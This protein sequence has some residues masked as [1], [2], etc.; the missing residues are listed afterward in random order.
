METI[1]KDGKYSVIKN[2]EHYEVHH[3]EEILMTPGGKVAHTL[4][5]PIAERLMKDWK[6]Q[7]YNS[8]T[9]SSSLLSYHF[10]M[11]ENFSKYDK[12]TLLMILNSLGW[13]NDVLLK[14]C[15]AADPHV[16]MEWMNLFGVRDERIAKIKAWMNNATPMQLTAMTCIYNEFMSY[17]IA[18]LMAV[19]VEHV[20][21]ENHKKAIK[22]IFNFY[23]HWDNMFTFDDFW[24][25]FDCFRL[26]YGE[27]FKE[28][29]KHLP[30]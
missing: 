5:L 16:V 27:H 7:G 14:S 21:E 30:D 22:D 19:V 28:Y 12:A 29:G 20:P 26:Y 15:P 24:D 11:V 9:S 4:Y 8:Y 23:S 2:G 25:I 3:G 18:Y 13:E 17:N 6:E 10:T 1:Q